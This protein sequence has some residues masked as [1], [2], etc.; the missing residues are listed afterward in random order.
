M[1]YPASR[2]ARDLKPACFVAALTFA[3]AA[4]APAMASAAGQSWTQSGY[5]AGK[6]WFNA[7][8]RELSTSNV[9]ALRESWNRQLGQF[10]IGPTAQARG[11]IIVCSN[12]NGISVLKAATGALIDTKQSLVGGDCGSPAIGGAKVYVTTSSPTPIN[13]YLTALDGAGQIVWTSPSTGTE[14][15]GFENPVLADGAVFV[16]DRRFAV[17]SFNAETGAINWRSE[18]AWL[19]NEATVGSGKV[20]VTTWGG[21][22]SGSKQLY[23]FNAGTGALAWSAPTDITN[24]EYPALITEGLAIAGSDSG[25]VRAFDLANGAPRWETAFP[26]YISAPLAAAG[27]LLYVVSGNATVTALKAGSG[28]TVW[29]HALKFRSVSSN[30]V[31]ANGVLYLTTT[32][33]NGQQLTTLDAATGSAL[34]ADRPGSITGS[35]GK[36]TVVDGRVQI[37]TNQGYLH[38]FALPPGG[39]QR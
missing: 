5:D 2:F 26:G 12:L 38:V 17:Y 10:Y 23:A 27:K 1:S 14:S 25:A 11:K 20:I 34:G 28:T 22:P 35:F 39:S 30:M 6:T 24:M 16:A 29:T 33:Q 13:G 18:T 19:N 4:G 9:G 32:D 31:V 7:T 15:L 21:S 8:E 37:S 36:L 3:L